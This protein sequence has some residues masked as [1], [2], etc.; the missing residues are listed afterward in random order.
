MYLGRRSRFD[1]ELRAEMQFHIEMRASELEASG[2]SH[3]DALAKARREFGSQ[4]RVAEDTRRVWRFQWLEDLGS[5]FRYAVRSFR[6]SPAFALSV[7]VSLAVGLGANSA[8]FT[9]VD[10]VFWKPLAVVE[11][12]RLVRVSVTRSSGSHRFDYISGEYLQQMREAGVFTDVIAQT[13]DGL[14]FAF[15]GR[16]ERIMGE[17]VS[18][19]FF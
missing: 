10:A 6:R 16:A 19:Q 1:D 4:M 5:D 17:A 2:L 11:P 18:P 7:G 15:D 14:S 12:D 13:S 3:G 9:A 8:V